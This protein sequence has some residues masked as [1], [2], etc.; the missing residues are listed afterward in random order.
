MEAVIAKSIVVLV[1]SQHTTYIMSVV[2]I[3]KLVQTLTQPIMYYCAKELSPHLLHGE[4]ILGD[5]T[6][7]TIVVPCQCVSTSVWV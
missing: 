5:V 6:R 2:H 7:K 4:M 3:I 1:P